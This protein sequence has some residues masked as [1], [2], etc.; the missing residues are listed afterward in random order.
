MTLARRDRFS[1]RWEAWFED[2]DAL[3]LPAAMT[4]AFPHRQSG[5]TVAVD[6]V[7]VGY[8]AHGF[9]LVFANLTGL[10]ALAVPAG[11]DEHG[12]AGRRADR[13]AP[14]VGATAAGRRPRA[15]A[16]RRP[17]GVSAAAII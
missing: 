11:R 7:A 9:P 14:L 5:G 6:G 10:P 17:P 1:A 8:E 2:V 15:R 16:G 12:P 4:G 3:I 13:R